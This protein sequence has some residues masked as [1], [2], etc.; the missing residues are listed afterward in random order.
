MAIYFYYGDEDFNIEQAI[1]KLKK[2]LDKNFIAMS[3]KT[4][5]NPHFPEL[6]EAVRAQGMMFG[7]MLTVI[8][9]EKY[10]SASGKKEQENAEISSESKSKFDDKQIKELENALNNTAENSDI[11]FVAE[12]PK[13]D[14][15][16]IDSRTKLFKLLAKFNAQEFPSFALN[17]YGKQDLEKWINKNAKS[18]NIAL[19]KDV[20]MFLIEQIGNNLRQLDMELE[21]LS[22][23]AYPK[24]DIT[25]EMVKEI[26]ISNEDIFHFIDFIVTQ[27]FDKAIEEYQKLLDKNHPLKILA[28]AQTELRKKILL[29]INSSKSIEELISITGMSQKQISVTLRNLGNI[30]LKNLVKLKENLTIA[31]HRVKSGMSVNVENE[32]QNAILR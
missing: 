19:D 27:N 20:P 5:D 29:K 25:I 12:L 9:C 11:V 18:K 17:Y 26:C 8:N 21:K 13:N 10:F 6:I 1:E 24:K 14:K 2:G 22:L 15:K 7:R 3:Y 30:P 4:F 32:V 28:T 23:L 16:K 31:E